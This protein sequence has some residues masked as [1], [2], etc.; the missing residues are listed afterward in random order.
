MKELIMAVFLSMPLGLHFFEPYPPNSPHTGPH[1]G[2][3]FMSPQGTPIVSIE[4]GVVLFVGDYL[5]QGGQNDYHTA[6]EIR[7]GNRLWSYFHVRPAP[8]IT[9]GALVQKGQI[10]GHVATCPLPAYGDHL[11]LELK[12]YLDPMKFLENFKWP[13]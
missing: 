5:G 13:K 7:A 9:A 1:L 6:I 12:M 2:Q 4:A 10:I 8:G 3:D 11:H